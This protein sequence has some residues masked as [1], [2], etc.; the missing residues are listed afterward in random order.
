MGALHAGHAALIRRARRIAGK[1]GLVVVSIF[2]NPAQFSPNEDFARYPRTLRAD[3]S[4]CKREGAD[5]IFAPSAEQMYA[6]GHS[7][8]IDEAALSAGLCGAARPGHFRGVCTVVGKLFNIVEPAVA[9]FGEKDWQQLAVIRRMTRDL[10]FPVRIVA[11]PTVRE[12]DGLAMSSRNRHLS[13]RERSQ[14]PAIHRALAN[15]SRAGHS[16]ASSARRAIQRDVL[17]GA[18]L[19]R[20]DYIEI[21]DGTTLTPARKIERGA[22]AAVAVFLGQTRLIDNIRLG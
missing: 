18:P 17:R 2:V 19:A 20:I 13:P 16:S 6:G 15:A 12:S 3:A 22:L 14:A 5:V 4:L 9:V 21:F 10:N 1:D 11:A 8:W 7:V